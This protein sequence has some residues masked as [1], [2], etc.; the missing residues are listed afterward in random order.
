VL[1]I[2]NFEGV[3]NSPADDYWKLRFQYTRNGQLTPTV[4]YI[5]F[6]PTLEIDVSRTSAADLNTANSVLAYTIFN[7]DAY[8]KSKGIDSVDFWQLMNFVLVGYYWTLLADLGQISSITYVPLPLQPL[9]DWYQLNLSQAT[10][11]PPINNIFINESLFGIYSSYLNNT[12]LPLLGYPPRAFAAKIKLQ[13]TEKTFLRSY[14]CQVR[15]LKAP[16]A[17]IVSIITTL[18]IF[19]TGPYIAFIKLAA[20]VE[21]HELTVRPLLRLMLNTAIS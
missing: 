15:Q 6:L 19:I 21:K 11:S 13:P 8:A 1:T 2:D 7:I 12:I 14:V 18:Y 10:S 17:A 9:P 20:M 5:T 3:T 16:L 4:I